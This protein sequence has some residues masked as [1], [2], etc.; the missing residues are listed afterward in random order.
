MNNSNLENNSNNIIIYNTLRKL[1]FR[2]N[3]SGTIFIVK[4]VNLMKKYS[5][6]IVINNI[7]I[8][9]SKNSNNYTPSQI[10]VDIK[11]AIDNRNEEKSIKNFKEI[12]GYDYDEEIFTNKDFIEEIYRIISNFY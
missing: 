4:A 1:G 9:L 6:K 8:E 10:R 3:H 7:Y 2:P 5:D 12:F 11:Y